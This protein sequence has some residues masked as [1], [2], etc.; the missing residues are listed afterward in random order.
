[1]PFNNLGYTVRR[2]F[3]FLAFFLVE[4]L[5]DLGSWTWASHFTTLGFI[6]LTKIAHWTR[7]MFPQELSRDYLPLNGMGC[8]LKYRVLLGN[9]FFAFIQL[10]SLG[11]GPGVLHLS[12]TPGDS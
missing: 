7:S 4:P 3:L 1:M 5:L 9:A 8:L 10:A 12:G 11:A 2:L 6:F